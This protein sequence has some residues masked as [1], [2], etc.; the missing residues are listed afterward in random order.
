MYRN[1]FHFTQTRKA[2]VVKT[3]W[4]RGLAKRDLVDRQARKK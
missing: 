1:Q 2:Y 3:V 4:S